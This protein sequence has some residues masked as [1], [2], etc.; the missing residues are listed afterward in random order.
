MAGH[1][2][3]LLRAGVSTEELSKDLDVKS[4]TLLYR[5]IV[6][7]QVMLWAHGKKKEGLAMSADGV[8]ALYEK[9][10]GV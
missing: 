8:W 3:G 7:A 6:Q 5:G 9:A 10:I 2:A 1:I 4:A